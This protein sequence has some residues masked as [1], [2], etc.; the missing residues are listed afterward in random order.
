MSSPSTSTSDT[1]DSGPLGLFGGTFDP[2]HTGHLRLAEEA[3][4]QLGLSGVRWIP[5]GDPRHRPTPQL[6]AG[7][8]LAMV[9]LATAGNPRFSVDTSEV[10]SGT[11]SYTVP[12]LERLRATLGAERPLV[13]LL[14]ADAFAG[15]PSWHRWTE[16]IGLAHLAIA[17]RPGFPLTP[18]DLPPPLVPL[19]QERLRPP[20]ALHDTPA[21]AIVPF[22][23]TPLAIS[24]TAIRALLASGRSTRYLLPDAVFDYI[25]NKNLYH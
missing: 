25:R 1:P 7:E 15:L 9:H 2:V 18:A 4:D 17:H 12:M 8:R 23:M 13:L 10:D 24:A 16:L 19:L 22:A 21:G 14:G 6:T 5:A 3:I 11:A 20:A